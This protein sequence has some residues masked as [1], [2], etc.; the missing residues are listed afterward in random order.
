MHAYHNFEF[1]FRYKSRASMANTVA[2]HLDSINKACLSNLAVPLTTTCK[3]FELVLHHPLMQ[4]ESF[5]I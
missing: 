4:C 2:D 5:P 3:A 1:L